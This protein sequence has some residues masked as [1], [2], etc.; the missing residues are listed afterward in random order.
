[1][2]AAALAKRVLSG[3]A[4]ALA[5][6][7]SIVEER[8]AEAPA[9]LREIFPATGRAFVIGVTGF[10]GAGKSSLVDRLT[11]TYRGEGLRVGV[12]AVDPS[13]AFS[14][15]AILGDRIRMMRHSTDP[16]V[17]IR[18]MATRGALGG[19]SRATADTVDLMDAAGHDVVIVET[20][21]VGQDEVDVVRTADTVL[22]VL[23]PGMGD[24]IQAIKAGI[25]EIADIFVIN[26]ADQAGADRLQAELDTMMS[27]G[28][29]AGRR[30]IVRT[31]AV[32]AEGIAE[33]AAA[34]GRHR[35]CAE[36]SGDGL[37]RRSRQSQ[38]RFLDL[39]RARL[40]DEA[41]AGCLPGGAV[42]RIAEDIAARRV[43]PYAA[44]ERVL[45]GI[46][47][48]GGDAGRG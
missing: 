7:I 3:E 23:V 42:E 38:S 10:P 2:S 43:D 18:S 45:G 16:G 1:V 12:V 32:R 19:L 36:S 4:R 33:L 13:S 9:L 34:V 6:A 30:E 27:L 11:A 22:V 21:G 29:A 39:L 40:L 15:G 26:K 44:V 8:S 28:A 48:S 24:D 31:V 47:F 25:L 20:V 5:R 35:V 14:G 37:R 41:V 17:F 46:T